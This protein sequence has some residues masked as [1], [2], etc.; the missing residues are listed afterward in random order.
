MNCYL[1]LHKYYYTTYGYTPLMTDS[2][3]YLATAHHFLEALN[4]NN[5]GDAV[6]EIYHPQAR[7]WHNFEEEY[8]DSAQVAALQAA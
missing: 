7:I 8:L 4:N 1:R 5:D 6:R 2:D 3:A